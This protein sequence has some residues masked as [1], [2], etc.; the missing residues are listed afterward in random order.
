LY[1][2]LWQPGAKGLSQMWKRS[3]T[4]ASYSV[5]IKLPGTFHTRLGRKMSVS[6][7]TGYSWPYI[8]DRLLARRALRLFHSASAQH[9]VEHLRFIRAERLYVS[10]S[11]TT[12]FESRSII[13]R[14]ITAHFPCRSR[15]MAQRD[16]RMH[17]CSG[18]SS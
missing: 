14:G 7:T 12:T 17:C 13:R 3:D 15:F 11:Y 2:L 4:P 10:S 16:G 8:L 9:Y 5:G 18:D 6:K 1:A